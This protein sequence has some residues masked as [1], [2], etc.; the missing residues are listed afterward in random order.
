MRHSTSPLLHAAVLNAAFAMPLR[1]STVLCPAS[2]THYPY[3]FSLAGRSEKDTSVSF[4]LFFSSVQHVTMPLPGIA[5]P[6]PNGAARCRWAALQLN[7]NALRY[8]GGAGLCFAL[9]EPCN[10]SLCCTLPTRSHAKPLH[11]KALLCRRKETPC[12]SV[13]IPCLS[14][15]L[16][17]PTKH[18]IALASPSNTAPQHRTALPWLCTAPPSH[19]PRHA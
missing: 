14:V 4:S 16:L 2:A 9:P 17:C 7:A 10:A 6:L 5:T 11:R 13:A 3:K 12:F 1:G 8:S 18:C 19:R 15:P